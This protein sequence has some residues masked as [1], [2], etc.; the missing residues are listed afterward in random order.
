MDK[1]C[2]A[3]SL[4]VSVRPA[5]LHWETAAKCKKECVG[6]I[7]VNEP[8]TAITSINEGVMLVTLSFPSTVLSELPLLVV[9][10]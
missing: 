1:G 8:N 6:N 9:S 4:L 10:F 5:T 7:F 2:E 3:V